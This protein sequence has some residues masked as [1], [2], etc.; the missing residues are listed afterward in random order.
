MPSSLSYGIFGNGYLDSNPEA[1][2]LFGP[3]LGMAEYFHSMYSEN[4]YII[5]FGGTTTKDVKGRWNYQTG[6]YYNSMI[7]FFDSSIMELVDD[8][9]D[10]EIWVDYEGEEEW[11]QFFIA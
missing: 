8:N 10:F 2:L 3:E 4:T 6:S 11:Q 7:E 1:G 5:K 9:I